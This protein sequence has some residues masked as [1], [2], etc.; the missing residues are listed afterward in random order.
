M[1]EASASQSVPGKPAKAGL[2]LI[3]YILTVGTF[4]MGT[5]EFIVA[6][7]LPEIAADYGVS[8]AQVGM[9]ITLFAV[10]MIFGAP[11]VARLTL[12]MPKRI[13]LMLALVVFAI[14]QPV[15]PDRAGPVRRGFAVRLDLRWPHRRPAPIHDVDVHGWHFGAGFGRAVRAFRRSDPVP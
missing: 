6:G 15:H 8:V 14:G 7:L 13:T 2:P 11:A 12:R 5:S 4:L 1:A 3:V 10:G 9:A